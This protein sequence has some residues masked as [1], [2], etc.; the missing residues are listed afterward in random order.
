VNRRKRH[1]EEGRGSAALF[2]PAGEKKRGRELGSAYLSR[3][4]HRS[5][6]TRKEGKA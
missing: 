4:L 5:E 1:E 3:Q 6:L 2:L